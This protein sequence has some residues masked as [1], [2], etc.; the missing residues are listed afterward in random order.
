MTKILV[1]LFLLAHAGIHASFISPRPAQTAGGPAWP[2]DLAHSWLLT[3][4][5]MAPDVTRVLGLALLAVTV[6]AFALAALAALGITPASLWTP[7]TIVGAA[8][9]IGLL[10]AFFHPWL[11]LG[12]VIDVALVWLVS[13]A[14]WQPAV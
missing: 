13:V 4:L 3:P 7:A 1:A 9:S 11:V 2:F 12:I 6:G 5:G 10:G 14:R 8:A